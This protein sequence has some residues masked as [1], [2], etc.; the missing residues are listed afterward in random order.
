MM[1]ISDI[2][3]GKRHR[4]DM[5]DI[6]S[7]AANISEL[8]LLHP[9]VVR[10]DGRLVAG[11]RR[12]RAAKRLGWPKVPVHMVDIDAIARGELAEN[13]LR[14]DFTPSE[15]VDIAATVEDEERKLAKARQLGALKRGGQKPVV[16]NFHDGGKARDKVA[17]PLG[18][19]GRTLEK[20]RA[21]VA[22][23]EAEPK[24]FGPLVEEMDRTGKVSAA[25]R[26]LRCAEDEKRIL[27][28]RPVA[29]K[30]LTLVLDPPWRYDIDFLGRS[31]PDYATMSKEE[32][33]ALAVADW[34]EENC[35]LYLW[36]TNAMLKH[37]FDVMEAWGFRYNTILT[38]VK[39]RAGMGT[40]FR[41]ATEH[42]LFGI[43]GVLATRTLK[44]PTWFEA[45]VGKHSEKPEKFY[46]IVRAASY[47]PYGEAFQ[48]KKRPD[49]ANLFVRTDSDDQAPS[50]AAAE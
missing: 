5:G 32:L 46:D 41:G 40:H 20:A 42:V 13:A 49:F 7:L 29:G 17:A 2:K 38:W 25:Y 47:P 31:R 30:H 44:I 33:L 6:E 15:I 50:A 8:G 37:A 12:L 43:R 39:P 16:E 1:L 14:K 36:S 22:A 21:V 35:H 27:G 26:T 34:A 11:E 19:S 4:R 18:I 45:P 23:A 9:V 28:L 48:R 3:V 10:P 24:R